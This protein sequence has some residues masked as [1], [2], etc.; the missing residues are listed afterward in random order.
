M[1]ARSRKGSKKKKKT[2]SECSIQPGTVGELKTLAGRA[3]LTTLSAATLTTLMTL[4]N[5]PG[6]SKI[7]QKARRITAL[8][9]IVT[10]EDLTKIGIS[11]ERGATPVVINPAIQVMDTMRRDVK[12]GSGV[13]M[14][15]PVAG[16]DVHEATLTVAIAG[17]EGIVYNTE[18][19]NDAK[20]I[21]SLLRLLEH[22]GVNHAAM[23]S[24]AEYWLKAC[25]A[26]QEHGV[27][28]LV[29]NAQQTKA[30]QGVKTDPKDARR[31]ALAFRD[32][33]LKPSIICTPEQQARRK[34]NRDAIKKSQQAAKVVSR[35]RAM[36]HVYDA[37]AWIT[38]LHD[39][40]RGQTILSNCILLHDLSSVE[41]MLAEAYATGR[42]HI[43]DEDV[44]HS[45][46]IELL[47]FMD[48]MRMNQKVVFRFA[49]NLKEFIF[50]REMAQHYRLE[51][52]QSVKDD[53]KFMDDLKL[54]LSCP[55]IGEDL[56]LTLLVE[57]VDIHHFWSSKALVKWSGMACRVNQSGF[58]KRSTGHVYLGGNKWIRWA[59]FNAARIDYAQ[60]TREG[61][62]IGY[63]VSRLYKEAKKPYKVAV[64]AGGRKLLSYVFHV[65]SLKKPFEELYREVETART[66]AN[67]RRK[68]SS[69]N[70]LVKQAAVSDL[71][72]AVVVSLKSH[73]KELAMVNKMYID[74]LN[75]LLADT[76]FVDPP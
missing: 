57:I 18:F 1:T 66:E 72:P 15:V 3:V 28:I 16:I 60:H 56:A 27:Q 65:L 43:E 22:Y 2:P 34:L 9:G 32:G 40:E 26:L 17:S 6:R 75:Q 20:G 46:A 58:K 44:L 24:T 8:E 5:L 48:R 41:N 38:E 12:P 51:L 39:S 74:T 49:Q 63:F 76:H 47:G 19:T 71:L 70:R 50:F 68:L 14:N 13:R 55:S 11:H 73:S 69:L 37:A 52:V 35:L 4:K 30:T 45:M 36:Y 21:E 10:L 67:K 25:W 54:L 53:V 64:L 61:H 7:R 62:P 23:E 33:R 59:M 42:G 29:A 31:I